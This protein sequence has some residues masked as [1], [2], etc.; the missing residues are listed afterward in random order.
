MARVAVILLAAICFVTAACG[1]DD[2]TPATPTAA[3]PTSS[4]PSASAAATGSPAVTTTAAS[5]FALTSAAFANNA[6]IP[7]EYSCDGKSSS[8]A[9][10]WTGAPDGTKSFA[11]VMHDPDAPRAGG[12]THWVLYDIPP[13]ATGL[14]AGASPGGPLPEGAQQGANGSGANQYTGPCPPKGGPAHHYSFTLYALDAALN[15]PAGKSKADVES[16]I[17]GH[18]LAQTQLTGLF[19]H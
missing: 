10:A 11:L 13:D 15:L 2:S 5:A 16:A 19:Q 6:D 1:D 12:F 3:G 4:A 14:S 18:V 7:V 9:L 8:P 17:Q